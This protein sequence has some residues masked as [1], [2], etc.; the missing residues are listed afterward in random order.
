MS[1]ASDFIRSAKAIG[2]EPRLDRSWVVW[3]PPLPVEMLLDA[4]RLSDEIAEELK[5]LEEL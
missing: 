3:K 5:G 2:C 1:E 4:T